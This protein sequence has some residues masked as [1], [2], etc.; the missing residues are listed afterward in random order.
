[1]CDCG[2]SI[3]SVIVVNQSHHG[4]WGVVLLDSSMHFILLQTERVYL[5]FVIALDVIP[6]TTYGNEVKINY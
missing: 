1:M 5:F 3:S 4:S 2:Q 6:I